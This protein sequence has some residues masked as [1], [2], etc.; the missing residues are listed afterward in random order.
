[1][2]RVLV[3][4]LIV[5]LGGEAR[6]ALPR[7]ASLSVCADQY[8]LALA[9]PEQI[10]ALSPDARDPALSAGAAEA[11]QFPVL[12]PSAETLIAAHPDIVLSEGFLSLRMRPL[13]EREGIRFKIL[14]PPQTIDGVAPLLRDLGAAIGRSDAGETAARAFDA[15]R[16]TLSAAAPTNPPPALYLLP[17]GTTAGAGTFIDGVLRLG[18]FSNLAAKGGINGWDRVPLETLVATP[19]R[20]VIASFFEVADTS[21][22]AGFATSPLA[23]RTLRDADVI[24]V[25]N[26]LWVCAGPMLGEAARYLRAH[27][28]ALQG[29]Q[30]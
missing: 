27:N 15:M 19:P 26:A 13:L 3:I 23:K 24:S 22:L 25:P 20:I 12:D 14:T 30:P 29:A 1:M 11:A 21:A 9:A 5:V 10:A 8:V 2:M 18:G 7:V 17:T 6:A 16:A 28:P 4:V